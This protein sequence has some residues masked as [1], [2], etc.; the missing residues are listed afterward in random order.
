MKRTSHACGVVIGA[1]ATALL[2]SQAAL[3]QGNGDYDGDFDVDGDD[4]FNWAGCMTGPAGGP[5]D[6]GCDAFDFPMNS[7]PDGNVDMADFWA[8]QRAATAPGGCTSGKKYVCAIQFGPATAG[9]GQISSMSVGYGG[10]PQLCGGPTSAILA[11]SVAWVGVIE[12][13]GG[14]SMKWAQTGYSRFRGLTDNTTNVFYRTFA[15]TQAG[16]NMQTDFDRLFFPGAG[17]GSGYHSYACI[18][19]FGTWYFDFD[20]NLQWHTFDHPGWASITGTSNDWAGEI[21]NKEDDMPGRV[22]QPCIFRNL[23]F[24]HNGIGNFTPVSQPL[25]VTTSDEN[26][27]GEGPGPGGL[28][29]EFEIWDIVPIPSP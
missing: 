7:A 11:A 9:F 22:D 24:I 8:F 18:L 15:E 27:W 16:P 26:E 23:E 14:V 10:I 5:L 19:F 4:F 25:L 20:S 12:R 28:V 3:G 17:P 6:P 1:I 13:V 21:F 29:N 2:A